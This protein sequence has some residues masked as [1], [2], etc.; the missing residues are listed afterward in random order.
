M[1]AT[2]RKIKMAEL[3]IENNNLRD[4]RNAHVRTNAELLK[5]CYAMRAENER[6]QAYATRLLFEDSRL[7]HCK[8]CGS[9][10]SSFLRGQP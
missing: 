9:E 8:K 2:D 5:E 3:R 7:W 10:F 1:S 4:D 6:L